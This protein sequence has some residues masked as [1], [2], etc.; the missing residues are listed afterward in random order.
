[1]LRQM[2]PALSGT[3]QHANHGVVRGMTL[4][5]LLGLIAAAYVPAP[6]PPSTG[7]DEVSPAALAA[8]TAPN[9][10]ATDPLPVSHDRLRRAGPSVSAAY[11]DYPGLEK[12]PDVRSGNVPPAKQTASPIQQPAATLL[13]VGDM[14]LGRQVSIEM[15]KR[16]DFSW[17]FRRTADLLQSADFTLGNLESPIV[18]GCPLSSEGMVFCAVPRSAEGLA[19]A[20]IDAVGL[21]NNHAYTYSELG[22]E[23]T[24][25]YLRRA[26]IEPIPPGALALRQINGIAVGVLSFDDSNALLDI[27][28]AAAATKE[29]ARNVD[30]LIGL[31]HWGIEY[32]AEPTERQREVGHALADAGMTVIVGTHPHRVQPAED[33]GDK[34]IVYSLGNF[35]FDQMWW[36]QTRRGEVV[37]LMLVST[38]AGVTFSYEMIPI[39]IYDYGQPA[40]T[41]Q[42]R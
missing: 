20:G 22:F 33:Y 6:V 26:G 37:R 29:V 13:I 39:E 42:R 34:L 32:Q 8:N 18:S 9:I 3:V 1:M 30:I 7:I 10:Q 21:A 41:V 2:T 27:N 40:L 31:M 23:Q 16:D 38:S 4:I 25:D 17:P 35:V 11:A 14:M 28:Q 36:E 15:T 12:N 24:V 5:T 19:W